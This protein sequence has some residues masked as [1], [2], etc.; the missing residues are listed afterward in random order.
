MMHQEAL[1]L[2]M[3]N[4]LISGPAFGV[5]WNYW[6]GVF[7]FVCWEIFSPNTQEHNHYP[8]RPGFDL[9]LRKSSFYIDCTSSGEIFKAHVGSSTY[10]YQ[11]IKAHKMRMPEH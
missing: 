3:P 6:L 7:Q 1:T 9:S 8:Q 11:N 4:D 2:W 5:R 10:Q